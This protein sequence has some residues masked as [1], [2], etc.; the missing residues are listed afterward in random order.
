MKLIA[1]FIIVA[2]IIKKLRGFSPP[3]NYTDLATADCR[4]S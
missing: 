2:I 4:R 1:V 3:P